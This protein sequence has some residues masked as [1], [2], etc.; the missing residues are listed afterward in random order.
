MLIVLAVTR[1]GTVMN[2]TRILW[3][4]W[5]VIRCCPSRKEAGREYAGRSGT[6]SDAGRVGTVGVRG[7]RRLARASSRAYYH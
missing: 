2:V 1:P 6:S 3:A 5:V 7:T 4:M